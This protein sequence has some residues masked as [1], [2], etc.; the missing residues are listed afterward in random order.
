M[1]LSLAGVQGFEPRSADPESAVLPLNDTPIHAQQRPSYPLFVRRMILQ[2]LRVVKRHV[3]AC[4]QNRLLTRRHVMPVALVTITPMAVLTRNGSNASI[5]Q[6]LSVD[7]ASSQ[8]SS[9]VRQEA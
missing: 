7:M 1:Y 3:A 2:L 8:R 9:D 4:A 5:F 6:G